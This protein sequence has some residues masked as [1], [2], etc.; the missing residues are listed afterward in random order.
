M[1]KITL[2]GIAGKKRVGKDT[3]AAHL[4]QTRGFIR[5]AF[6]DPIKELVT[7]FF[8][9]DDVQLNDDNKEVVDPRH[10]LSP[11]QMM[12]MLGTDFGRRMIRETF[13]ND[14]FEAWYRALPPGTK[15]VVPDVRFQNEVD[16]VRSLGGIVLRVTR[17]PLGPEDTHASEAGVDALTGIQ[18][19][20]ENNGTKR[21]LW[22]ALDSCSFIDTLRYA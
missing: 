21:D 17:E 4:L 15:V 6:A 14:H 22:N 5:R 13:W 12:Q 8:Q 19:T 11:R 2:V 7:S 16:L 10:N 3:A 20:I 9:L 18:A 1:E